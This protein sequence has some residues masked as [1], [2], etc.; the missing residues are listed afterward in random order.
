MS[1][2]PAR[3]WNM[4]GRGWVVARWGLVQ[5]TLLGVWFSLHPM[6]ARQPC[7]AVKRPDIQP[8][9]PMMCRIPCRAVWALGATLRRSL[10][11]PCRR[12]LGLS[13]PFQ[14]VRA[15]KL[16]VETRRA[17][18]D[19]MHC[20]DAVGMQGL[21]PGPSRIGPRQAQEQAIQII[22]ESSAWSVFQS[23]GLAGF[24][25]GRRHIQKSGRSGVTWPLRAINT[26]YINR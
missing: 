11:E 6:A 7:C 20:A 17:T 26:Q 4:L 22:T 2:E 1:L 9:K 21:A 14:K 8:Q 15:V 10:V 25:P 24:N 5:V 19:R 16:V 18:P 23:K 12:I 3:N 13:T